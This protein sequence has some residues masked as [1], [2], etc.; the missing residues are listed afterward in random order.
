LEALDLTFVLLFMFICVGGGFIQRVSGFG[1]G[2]FVMLFLPHM[3]PTHTAAAAIAALMSLGTTSYNA[4]RNRK[5]ISFSLILPLICSAVVCIP[6]AI[7]L[8]SKMP[9][10][11][12]RILLGIVLIVLSIY[13]LF[14]N[15]RIHLKPTKLNG[16]LTGALGGFLSGL[17]AT[18]GPPVVLYLTHATTDKMIYFA[19][20]QFYFA[21]T[22]VWST[23]SRILNGIITWNV[24]LYAVI[25]LVGCACGNYFGGKVF[26][27]LDSEKLKKVI[28]IGMIIS[29]AS[30]LL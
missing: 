13:F 2:I 3:M 19:T 27:K 16:V 23:I 11:F 26:A 30:M 18:G 8:S 24:L 10:Q 21:F 5:H 22:N 1:L 4:F 14:F 9:T 29:G 25:G 7:M 15:R 28:Y 20:I 12:F 6:L 17:F